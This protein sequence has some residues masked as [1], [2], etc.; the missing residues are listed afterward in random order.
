MYPNTDS[1]QRKVRDGWHEI[2][3]DSDVQRFVE[4][5][6]HL[7]LKVLGSNCDDKRVIRAEIYTKE[8]GDKLR[9]L[10]SFSQYLPLRATISPQA[11]P[12]LE[13]ISNAFQR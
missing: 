11:P 9:G 4:D 2:R 1:L 3:K 5:I 7:V 6:G 10:M 13:L 12:T 8:T